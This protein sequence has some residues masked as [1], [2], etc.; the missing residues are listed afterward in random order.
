MRETRYGG[1]DEQLAEHD[2]FRARLDQL[3]AEAQA[4][5]TPRLADSVQRLLRDWFVE[6]VRT[7]DRRLGRH[8]ARRGSPTP[9]P[10]RVAPD[11]LL[12]EI[13][14]AA[15]THSLWKARLHGMVEA[16]RLGFPVA[17]LRDDRAC[18][19]GR[20]I[21]RLTVPAGPAH[22]AA[23]R[24]VVALHAELHRVAGQVGELLEAGRRDEALRALAADGALGHASQALLRRL[25]SWQ[26]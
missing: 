17:Q 20:W 26:A 21:H 11:E 18:A 13:A 7:L 15:T 1:L 23:H 5:A 14:A 6:H 25:V 12:E 16:G 10:G 2:L 3:Q 4:G 8:L 9:V 19:F 22:A 24:E